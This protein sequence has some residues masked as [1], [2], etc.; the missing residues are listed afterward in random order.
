MALID[1]FPHTDIGWKDIG[2][3]FIRYDLFKC[4]WFNLYLHRLIAE[5]PHAQCHNHPWAFLTIILKGG[6]NEYTT[7]SGWLWRAPG[8]VL[9]RPAKHAHNVTTGKS[10]MWSLVITGPKNRE[11]GFLTC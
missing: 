8:T 1:H 4:R 2:E 3:T 5:T 9:W 6:Y 10:G 11:W 7:S